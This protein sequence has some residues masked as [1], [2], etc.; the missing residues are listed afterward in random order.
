M[1]PDPISTLS[2]IAD[3]LEISNDF[4]KRAF[5]AENRAKK[6]A[7]GTSSD[8][9]I[10]WIKMLAEVR[11]DSIA[12]PKAGQHY[13][14]PEYVAQR[15]RLT[16]VGKEIARIADAWG[17]DNRAILEYVMHGFEMLK[18]DFPPAIDVLIEQMEIRAD[19]EFE[20]QHGPD[21]QDNGEDPN[22]GNSITIDKTHRAILQALADANL[23][24]HAEDIV[25][26]MDPAAACC[27]KSC[28]T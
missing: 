22:G 4:S 7:F 12:N 21:Q 17:F 23:A 1:K 19:A 18:P 10:A 6:K 5:E 16:E 27:L 20:R 25:E 26:W 8:V 28:R 3:F 11:G 24:M 14:H 9:A 13:D 15:L 2:L